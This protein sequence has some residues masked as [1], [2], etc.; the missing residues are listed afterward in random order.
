MP[1]TEPI[2]EL[3]LAEPGLVVIDLAAVDGH[4][5]FAGNES[6]EARRSPQKTPAQ[7]GTGCIHRGVSQL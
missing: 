1:H 3:H 6:S 5:A 4:T 7:L 2:N